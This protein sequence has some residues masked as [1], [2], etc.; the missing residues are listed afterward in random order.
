[1]TWKDRREVNN[2]MDKNQKKRI[3]YDVQVLQIHSNFVREFLI[4]FFFL[5]LA[6]EDF[7]NLNSPKEFT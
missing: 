1:M 4:F 7:K 2:T 5:N 3:C 6:A